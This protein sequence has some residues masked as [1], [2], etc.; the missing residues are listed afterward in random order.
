MDIYDVLSEAKRDLDSHCYHDCLD[1]LKRVPQVL[2]DL[3][4]AGTPASDLYG[5]WG[6]YY[7]YGIAALAALNDPRLVF[8]AREVVDRFGVDADRDLLYCQDYIVL[9]YELRNAHATLARAA[10]EAHDV[11]TAVAEIEA[12][13]KIKSGDGEYEDPFL[14][15][16]ETKARVYLEAC[17]SNP[18]KFQRRHHAALHL[19]EK[20]SAADPYRVPIADQEVERA[21]ADPAYLEFKSRDPIEKLRH[22]PQNEPWSAA[23]ARYQSMR[24]KLKVSADYE[25]VQHL[26]VLAKEDEPIL[27]EVERQAGVQIPAALRECY[28]QYG[29]F[30]VRDPGSWGSLKLY[31]STQFGPKPFV[32]GV[33]GAIEYVWG[34]R[35]EFEACFSP[36]EIRQLND[37]YFCFGHYFHDD[38]AYS[39]LVFDRAGR[40]DR[41]YYHQDDWDS[42]YARFKDL[43]SE[44]DFALTFDALI[45]A[46]IDDIIERLIELKQEQEQDA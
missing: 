32:Q 42:A 22:G 11:K 18:K 28:A 4:R 36:D 15:S 9:R 45:S 37:Q 35:P 25:G 39:H 40:F 46:C 44:S 1:A 17:K 29:A 24:K 14:A 27:A 31:A 2:E 10:L 5:F 20:K 43:L 38:N 13:F 41:L 3:R 16:Y 23:L 26:L 33:V 12:C 7:Q 30:C 6:W 34:G 8:L 19:L 21:L